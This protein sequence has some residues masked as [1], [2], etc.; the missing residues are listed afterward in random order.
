MLIEKDLIEQQNS[1]FNFNHFDFK[2]I[3]LGLIDRYQESIEINKI[4]MSS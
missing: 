1:D 4:K 2:T 3:N